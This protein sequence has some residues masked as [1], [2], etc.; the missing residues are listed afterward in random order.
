MRC[1][2]KPTLAQ[3]VERRTVVDR[4]VDSDTAFAVSIS[5]FV[6]SDTLFVGVSIFTNKLQC[7]FHVQGTWHARVSF[8]DGDLIGALLDPL[9]RN[10]V[11]VLGGDDGDFLKDLVVGVKSKA[12]RQ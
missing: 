5:D 12:M 9:Q 8:V 6:D 4:F 7:L 1:Y 10:V 2:H 3:L 11:E